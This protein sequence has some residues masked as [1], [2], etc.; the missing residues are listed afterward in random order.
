MFGIPYFVIRRINEKK[1]FQNIKNI[2][3]K[4]LYL[5]SFITDDRK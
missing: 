4:I 3:K 2:E 1:Y 5:L